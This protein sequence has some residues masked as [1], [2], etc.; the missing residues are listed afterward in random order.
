[1][2]FLHLYSLSSIWLIVLYSSLIFIFI[3]ILWPFVPNKRLYIMINCCVTIFSA[4]HCCKI[5]HPTCPGYLRAMTKPCD[6]WLTSTLRSVMSRCTLIQMLRGTTPA[7]ASRSPK[8]VDSSVRIG[9]AE[10][11]INYS[12]CNIISL[13]FFRDYFCNLFDLYLNFMGWDRDFVQ[14]SLLTYWRIY[15][16]LTIIFRNKCLGDI[17]STYWGC[18]HLCL[19]VTLPHSKFY[20][21]ARKLSLNLSLSR[22]VATYQLKD[23]FK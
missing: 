23:T 3:C 2:T 1:M 15:Y 20:T 5:H 13:C 19:F 18:T 16:I 22:M 8:F 9:S 12:A 10:L 21:D 11:N 4:R 6:P 14:P 17:D 7:A